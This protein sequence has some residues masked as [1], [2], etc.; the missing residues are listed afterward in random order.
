[1]PKAPNPT[2]AARELARRGLAPFATLMF[3]RF[4][5][6]AHLRMVIRQL[7]RV[8]R[9]EIDRL[10]LFLPPRHG[11]SLVGSQLYPAW[12]LGRHPDRSVIASSYGQE[13]AS[14]FGRKVRNTMADQLFESLFPHARVSPDS[15][16]AHRFHLIAGGVYVATGV[17]GALTGRGA[18][19]LIIDDPV[20]NVEDANSAIYRSNLHDWYQSVAYTRLHPGGAV[21]LIQTRWH[22]D[23]LAGW[24]LREH[25]DQGWKVLDL[26]A[27]AE[28][29]D[30][31]GRVEGEALWPNRFPSKVLERTR[32]QIGS[33]AWASL[34]Q[35]K[36]A[37]LEGAV[38]KRN[39]W[40]YY[41]EATLPPRFESILISLDTAF[42]V[43]TSNDYSV[44]V[45]LGVAANG[46]FVL[47]LMR[48]RYEFPA[49]ERQVLALAERWKP[50][51]ILLEDKASGQS[52]LQTLRLN[53]RLP[54]TP[55]RVDT[56]KLSRAHA[57]TALVEMGNVLLPEAAPWLADF[58]DEVSSFPAAPHDDM[59]D[60][61]T[62][63]LNHVRDAS[64][65][66]IWDFYRDQAERRARGE[67]EPESDTS[68]IDEYNAE[69]K[70]LNELEDKRRGVIHQTTVSSGSVPQRTG[71]ASMAHL[72]LRSLFGR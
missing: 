38:F 16:A 25:A 4:E 15:T 41:T 49:L 23:D 19:L 44:G 60:A 47:D 13:L 66:G 18:D 9:G 27:I 12:Y 43:G 7:E 48:G 10:M 50:E 71:T 37:A 1:M 31:L 28:P 58:L 8:E 24:L 68:M 35:Q 32:M 26:P 33:A 53:S 14:D 67:P 55:V 61:L 34:Y 62:Q 3:R 46:Y 45:V 69:R 30:E 72:A 5:L 65:G 59:V 56:D 63:A 52:L 22:E 70:R 2:E 39:W 64:P 51:R 40:R 6:A 17:G 21:V 54:I 29:D 20:K 11:K 36:P 57:V 42:K